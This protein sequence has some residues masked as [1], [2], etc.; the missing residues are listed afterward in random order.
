M[1]ITRLN[2]SGDIIIKK[3]SGGGNSGGSDWRYY[4]SD[5]PIQKD[6]I[7]IIAHKIK[8]RN[9]NISMATI[10]FSAGNHGDCVAIA[11]DASTI[12]KDSDGTRTFQEGLDKTGFSE[13]VMTQLG[14]KR[15]TE[16]EF[17]A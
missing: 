10:Y 3:G 8:Y 2:S 13:E 9:G 4:A 17:Y 5:T 6:I 1:N 15:I 11:Y 16:E 14:L 7:G 12:I